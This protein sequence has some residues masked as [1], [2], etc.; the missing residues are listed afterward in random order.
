MDNS[1]NL[2]DLFTMRSPG[3]PVPEEAA[4]HRWSD[5]L[6][7]ELELEGIH[8]PPRVQWWLLHEDGSLRNGWEYVTEAPLYG[9]DVELALDSFYDRVD[10]WDANPR[11]S[12]HI[13][14]DFSRE[15]VGTLRS[16]VVIV[17]AL[18][19]GL[20][21]VIGVDRKWAGYAAPLREMSVNRLRNLLSPDSSALSFVEAVGSGRGNERYYGLN[22]SSL[23]RHGS[24]EFRYFPGGPD[25]EEL[26]SWM[27]LVLAIKRMAMEISLDRLEQ[28]ATTPQDMVSLFA[29]FLPG[30][31][32]EKLISCVP[33]EDIFRALWEA[34]AVAERTPEY[35]REV[36]LIFLNPMLIKVAAK[37]HNLS[38]EGK[39]ALQRAADTLGVV[40]L[41]DWNRILS[42]AKGTSSTST[43]NPFRDEILNFHLGMRSVNDHHRDSSYPPGYGEHEVIDDDEVEDESW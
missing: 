33:V 15:T 4:D 30:S 1:T 25:R 37:R 13:H 17:Y 38:E 42:E 8:D 20:Y 2:R 19:A 3:R 26:E 7:L 12:T 18:E 39:L 14:V 22:I 27:D 31:F 41:Q 5:Y 24:L 23:R 11:T 16:M 29:G 35:R 21:D 32:M 34:M 28:E 43:N 6:G 36:P 40:S 10:S 9:E